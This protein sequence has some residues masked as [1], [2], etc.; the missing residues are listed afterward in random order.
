LQKEYALSYPRDDLSSSSSFL[1]YPHVSFLLY[2]RVCLFFY[3]FELIIT[4]CAVIVALLVPKLEPFISLV[5]AI[6]F[7]IL[8]ISIPAVVETISCWESHLGTLNWRLWKNSLLI[9]FSLL[10]LIFGSWISILDI[11]A[12]Y[13]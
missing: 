12:I 13:K 7:S 10:A 4:I 2:L 3:L 8:G 11:M 6:F 5:G 1:I 9:V